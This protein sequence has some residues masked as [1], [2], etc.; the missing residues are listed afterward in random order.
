M[1]DRRGRGKAN[2]ATLLATK[3]LRLGHDWA[4]GW[5]MERAR[6]PGSQKE[7][8]VGENQQTDSPWAGRRG[9][10]GWDELLCRQRGGL[11]DHDL[12]RL[13]RVQQSERASKVPRHT[14]PTTRHTFTPQLTPPRNASVLRV[15]N[16]MQFIHHNTHQSA[17]CYLRS[18][19][20]CSFP[21]LLNLAVQN[22]RPTGGPC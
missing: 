21:C 8:F 15:L 17:I 7:L 3:W 19:L 22:S 18:R 6:Q 4:N 10:G 11:D 12:T 5:R 20:G 13:R 14:L 1:A 9:C 2:S 16:S